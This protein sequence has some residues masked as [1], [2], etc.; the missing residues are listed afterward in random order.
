MRL[1]IRIEGKVCM[2]YGSHDSGLVLYLLC[3]REANLNV[4]TGLLGVRRPSISKIPIAV[5]T[6]VRDHNSIPVQVVES[7]SNECKTNN[8]EVNTRNPEDMY[9]S[10]NKGIATNRIEMKRTYPIPLFLT[11]NHQ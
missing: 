7:P 4:G 6:S 11:T 10:D 2:L 5:P 3:L 8:T 1:Q 9:A